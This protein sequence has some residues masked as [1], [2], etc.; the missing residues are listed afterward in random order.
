M[1]QKAHRLRWALFFDCSSE[2]NSELVDAGTM[3]YDPTTDMIQ[4]WDGTQWV[5]WKTAGLNLNPLYNNGVLCSYLSPLTA[6]NKDVA[7]INQASPYTYFRNEDNKLCARAQGNN[8]SGVTGKI[9]FILSPSLD[10]A[11]L[12]QTYTKLRFTGYIHDVNSLTIPVTQ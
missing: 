11:Q 2:L 10:F 12:S 7:Y 9:V 6:L 5:D 8:A 3:K 4:L 1:N